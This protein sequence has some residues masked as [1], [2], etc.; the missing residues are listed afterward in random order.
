MLRL[1][2]FLDDCTNSISWA[3]ETNILGSLS[4]NIQY[5]CIDIDL[6]WMVMALQWWWS[7]HS[8]SSR[9][10]GTSGTIVATQSTQAMA[11]A[12][13]S[14]RSTIRGC[15]QMQCSTG[16]GRMCARWRL[17]F[18]WCCLVRV[19]LVVLVIIFDIS[20]ICWLLYS[21]VLSRFKS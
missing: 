16:I 2:F 20:R 14:T 9:N 18:S 15:N 3:E 17:D 7:S 1:R 4:I 11:M 12:I 13:S 21:M 8:G 19:V 6:V 10:S 5:Q